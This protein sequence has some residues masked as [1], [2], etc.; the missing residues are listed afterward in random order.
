M[1]LFYG[2]HKCTRI[3]Q[4]YVAN[5][6][7]RIYYD[8]C[9]NLRPK[10][11][12]VAIR[13]SPLKANSRA[14]L[15]NYSLLTNTHTK[16]TSNIEN[17]K[18]GTNDGIYHRI[19]PSPIARSMSTS[20]SNLSSLTT[21]SGS[22]NVCPPLEVIGL[23]VSPFSSNGC[24]PRSSICNKSNN[25]QTTSDPPDQDKATKGKKSTDTQAPIPVAPVD[26][27]TKRPKSSSSVEMGNTKIGDGTRKTRQ[28][29]IMANN[30]Q[31]CNSS[32]KESDILNS[33]TNLYSKIVPSKRGA[34]RVRSRE[35][36]EEL[37]IQVSKIH[38]VIQEGS[39][40]LW[41]HEINIAHDVFICMTNASQNTFQL[42]SSSEGPPREMECQSSPSSGGGEMSLNGHEEESPSPK[43][44]RL[45][46]R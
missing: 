16:S 1:Q 39:A 21:N 26:W 7:T 33:N 36:V 4:P 43:T 5:G 40:F 24:T 29:D 13:R 12:K 18:L 28:P 20:S 17:P 38:F 14:P 34:R 8:G 23:S 9:S 10:T 41:D 2:K 3:E 11:S 45:S 6:I 35:I 25:K 15:N 32:G 19:V 22:S 44:T 42:N 30:I 46:L 31:D 27:Q 37:Q